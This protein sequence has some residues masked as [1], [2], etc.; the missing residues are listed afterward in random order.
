MDSPIVLV[1]QLVLV[2]VLH[3]RIARVLFFHS[4]LFISMPHSSTYQQFR[5]DISEPSINIR[6]I[7]FCFRVCS[8]NCS[9]RS[10]SSSSSSYIVQ[11]PWWT[12]GSR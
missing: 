10:V 9:I 1:A 7:V 5:S 4:F 12:S 11:L 8:F 2:L 3:F 6:D